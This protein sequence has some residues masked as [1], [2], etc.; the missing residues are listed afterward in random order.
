MSSLLEVMYYYRPII[1][2]KYE[3]FIK[4]FG[5]SINFGYYSKNNSNEIKN[6]LEKIINMPN[7]EYQK[8]AINAHESVKEF[9]YDSYI[10]KIMKLTKK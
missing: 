9:T 4:T 7:Q 8:L 1:T 2:S 10:D 6:I 5:E 3:E